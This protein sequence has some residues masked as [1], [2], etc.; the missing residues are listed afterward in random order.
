MQREADFWGE[1]EKSERHSKLVQKITAEMDEQAQHD[2]GSLLKTDE[3]FRFISWLINRSGFFG[4]DMTGNSSTYYLS[5][6]RDFGGRIYHMVA[7]ID[8]MIHG[9]FS[10]EYQRILKKLRG[11]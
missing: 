10:V 8:P 7:A 9:K 6:Q 1:F 4:S 5:G 11:E 2:L 3:G